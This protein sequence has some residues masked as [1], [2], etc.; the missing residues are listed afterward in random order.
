MFFRGSDY[1]RYFFF[2][3]RP[4]KGYSYCNKYLVIYLQTI[5]TLIDSVM[6]ILLFVN[7]YYAVVDKTMLEEIIF[8]FVPY[9][10]AILITPILG[11]VLVS[12]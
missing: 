12:S 6:S 10:L 5:L 8:F 11:L 9:P 3:H 4:I 1:Y 7:L 2:S